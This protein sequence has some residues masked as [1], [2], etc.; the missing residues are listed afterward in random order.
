MKGIAVFQNK[1]KGY[2][3][4]I[5]EDSK[6]VVK[7]NGKISNLSPGKHGFHVHKYGNLLKTDCTKCGGHFR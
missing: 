3:T 7:I 2:V 6:S 4:F 5:Q 1:L